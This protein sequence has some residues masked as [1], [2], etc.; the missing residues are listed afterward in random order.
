MADVENTL[1]RHLLTLPPP[2]FQEREVGYL[3]ARVRSDPTVAKA[4]F[5]RALDLFN[6]AVF[7]SAGAGLLFWLDWKLALVA[8]AVLPA[9]ALSSRA[10][11]RRL[12]VLSQGIQEG[13]AR[14]SKELGEGSPPP[15]R[16]SSSGFPLGRRGR[17]P[18]PSTVSRRQTFGRTRS[19]P[20]R[21]GA[22]LHCWGGAG[23]PPLPWH[24]MRGDLSLG[25]VTAFIIFISYLYGPAQSI[26]TT[27]LGLQR[28]RVAASRI[29]EILD[30]APE[31]SGKAALTIHSGRLDVEGVS[32]TY[33]NATVALRAL[34]LSVEPGTWVALVGRTGSGKSTL[35]SLLVGLYEPS[36][37]TICIDGQDLQEVDLASLRE[38]VLLVTR[39]VFLFSTMVM[40]NLQ[41]GDP[42]ISEEV[43]RVTQALGAHGFIA[44]LP[45][46][47]ETLIGERGV[48]LSGGQ[49]QLL[50]LA[51]A[52]LRRPKISLSDEATSAM[53]S[54][55]EARALRA[56][57]ELRR[58]KPVIVAAHRLATVQSAGRLFIL[59]DR[60]VA[61]TGTHADLI[62]RSG[63]YRAIFEEQLRAAEGSEV[64]PI[65]L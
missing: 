18:R 47:Y 7:P 29:L 37:G 20:W 12:Q 13:D 61:E 62:H 1:V 25:T 4:F 48:K 2:F 10:L 58:G 8:A 15:S 46:G 22:R 32:F 57:V 3:M 50:A 44:G 42:A 33:P 43:S 40:E 5:L 51:R 56:L 27:N 19:V 64:G 34:S 9:L 35:L 54:E 63:E 31:P 53:D 59:K 16:L 21:G 49:K 36:Q 60:Q 52:V 65:P 39:D 28:A 38:Q 14:L 55:T 41:C 6:N 24:I 30:E 26:I 11:N 17:S 45:R 23:V